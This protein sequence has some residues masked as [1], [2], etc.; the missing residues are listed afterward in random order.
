MYL[1]K[2]QTLDGARSNRRSPIEVFKGDV[3]ICATGVAGT[4][5]GI[6]AARKRIPWPSQQFMQLGEI[7]S[8]VMPIRPHT[9]IETQFGTIC[10]Y[11][12]RVPGEIVV[13]FWQKN[14][15]L[16]RIANSVEEAETALRVQ[17]NEEFFH[18]ANKELDDGS[19]EI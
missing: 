10:Q 9:L 2:V 18:K 19:T 7:E 13:S 3:V 12:M 16:V 5:I 4:S 6:V 14:S 15:E 8:V 1:L 11:N 17:F